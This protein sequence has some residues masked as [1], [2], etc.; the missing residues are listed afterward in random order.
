[1]LG[2]LPPNAYALC[3]CV[4][5]G[6]ALNRRDFLKGI[7]IGVGAAG[8]AT[9]VRESQPPPVPEFASLKELDPILRFIEGS[10]PLPD[11]ALV[12]KFVAFATALPDNPAAIVPVFMVLRKIMNSKPSPSPLYKAKV[13]NSKELVAFVDKHGH[14]L[15]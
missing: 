3:L 4:C 9:V 12:R 2:L 15:A 13:I 1:M 6:Q 8:I 7:G 14:W 5:K 10:G 11:E